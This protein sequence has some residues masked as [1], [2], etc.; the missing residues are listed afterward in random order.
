MNYVKPFVRSCC[1]SRP[2]CNSCG[3]Y[4]FQAC[5]ARIDFRCNDFSA[6]LY[7]LSVSHICCHY[8]ESVRI[9]AGHI[10][11]PE[12]RFGRWATWRPDDPSHPS[13]SPRWCCWS[14]LSRSQ[15]PAPFNFTANTSSA[16]S[17][18]Q[19]QIFDTNSCFVLAYI[20]SSFFRLFYLKILEHYSKSNNV[21]NEESYSYEMRWL[22]QMNK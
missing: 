14:T 15:L 11:H 8:F 7:R 9:L 22:F 21:P 20:F 1:D 18:F 17:T 2:G 12:G 13:L 6:G 3:A 4:S 19:L 16:I 5:R 10:S